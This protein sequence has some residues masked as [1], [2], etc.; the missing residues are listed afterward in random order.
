MMSRA[1]YREALRHL[2]L[3]G[4]DG[5][6]VFNPARPGFEE[7]AVQEVEDAA[8]V[9]G[10]MLAFR[11]FLDDGEVMNLEYLGPLEAGVLWSGLRLE[12]E[13][14]VRVAALGAKERTLALEPWPGY[15]IDLAASRTGANY[16]LRRDPAS[17][18][19]EIQE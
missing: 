6:Q 11:D 18:S 8:R 3:R 1:A 5:M 7:I 12:D 2:W 4:I 13:A 17:R 15:R 9:Y 10:E 16:R 14:V 19:V